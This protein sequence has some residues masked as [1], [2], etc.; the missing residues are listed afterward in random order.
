MYSARSEGVV[1][2]DRQMRKCGEGWAYCD[3]DCF[4]C[5][6]VKGTTTT[7]PILNQRYWTSNKT[8][9]EKEKNK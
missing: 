2:M 9:P 1:V 5:Y 3:G 8:E 6:S 7:E 4:H